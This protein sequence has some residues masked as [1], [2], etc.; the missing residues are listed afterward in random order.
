M[1]LIQME[2]EKGLQPSLV[3]TDLAVHF[4]TALCCEVLVM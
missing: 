1:F 3:V 2:G 4:L